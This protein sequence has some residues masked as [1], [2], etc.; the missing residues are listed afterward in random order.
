M[1]GRGPPGKRLPRQGLAKQLRHAFGETGRGLGC[2][3]LFIK[4]KEELYCFIAIHG[5]D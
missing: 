2:I 4:A 3:M 5:I 1:W